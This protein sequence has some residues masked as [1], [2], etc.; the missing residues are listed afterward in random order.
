VAY[1]GF[2]APSATGIFLESISI[3]LSIS[4]SVS[5]SLSISISIARC[6]VDRQVN[7]TRGSYRYS[8]LA[9]AS[10]FR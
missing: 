9:L 5:L 6:K 4:I 1:D 3:S 8:I 10:V 7:R 2:V